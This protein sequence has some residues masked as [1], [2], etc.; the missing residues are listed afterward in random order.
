MPEEEINV[1]EEEETGSLIEE[2]PEFS[3]ETPDEPNWE[4]KAVELEAQ[5]ET[6]EKRRADTQRDWQ[7]QQ[8]A[9]GYYQG[10]LDS[11]SEDLNYRESYAE[12]MARAEPPQVEDADDL[13]TD[14]NKLL[15]YWQQRDQ[16]IVGNIMAQLEPVAA[17]TQQHESL[18]GRMLKKA[19]KDAYEE[20]DGMLEEEYDDYTK[21]DLA[22]SWELVSGALNRSPNHQE[23][24]M[25]PEA[26]IHAYSAIRRHNR[27]G[28]PKPVREQQNAPAGLQP[29]APGQRGESLPPMPAAFRTMAL[30][31][32][33][34]PNK[35]WKRHIDNGG[36]V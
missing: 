11:V 26:L 20:A 12:Q 9:L 15:N 13:L 10:A 30:N 24:R 6:S 29:S 23:Q 14:G 32:G 19:Q 34:N 35:L 22:K 25:D 3:S 16:Y 33:R 17:R 4:A 2:G 18:M 36:K 31:I 28:Q 8:K 7:E 21:G 5:L 27:K 1:V